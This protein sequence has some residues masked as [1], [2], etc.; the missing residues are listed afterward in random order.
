LYGQLLRQAP[1]E[2]H[3]L[4][5][6]PT[7]T[8]GAVYTPEDRYEKISFDDMD[9]EA[10]RR[11]V[12]GGW[13]AMMQHYFVGAWMPA[14]PAQ[15][16]QLYTNALGSGQYLIGYKHTAPLVVPAGGRGSVAIDL[17]AGP[18]EHT[19]LEKQPEGLKLTADYGW[20]T[21]IA[22]PLFWLL[23][24]IN[25]AVGNWGWSIIVL[26]ILIKAAFFPLN[27]AQYKSMAKMKKVGPR[28]QALKERY[29]NDRER[30]SKE[31]M[32]LYKKEK[33]NPMAGCLPILIQI[34]VFIALY[35]VLLE[36]VEMR[37]APF[38][39]WIKDLSSQDPYYVLPVLMGASMFVTTWMSPA[40]D[41]MQRRIFLAM[42]VV[43]TAFFL[44]FPAG[45]VL[46]WLVN[47]LL[48][49]A[50]QWY[51]TRGIEKAGG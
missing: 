19:R 12:N 41:P 21:F 37:H 28:L 5:M 51:I 42:P 49:I 13:V 31:M 11:D 26:T 48:Q 43:F 3:G 18:K 36:A 20:L 4:F 24:T 45:L 14:D 16:A 29:G 35:W 47:N 25:K 15:P 9:K 6:L 40:T 44:F 1:E 17:Y 33:I 46:Y 7:F 34:P 50:Q 39:L 27:N 30:Y 38:A 2:K 8:G 23:A 32:E 10:I 22:S